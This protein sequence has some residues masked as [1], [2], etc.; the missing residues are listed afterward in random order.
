[1]LLDEIV[2]GVPLAL[3]ALLVLGNALG[4]AGLTGDAELSSGDLHDGAELTESGPLAA[5][6]VGHVPLSIVLML[7]TLSFGASG[8]VALGVLSRVTS[9]GIGLALSLVFALLA[10]RFLTRASVRWLR[11]ILPSVET[12]ASEKR[13]LVGHSGTV[14]IVVGPRDVVMRVLDPG[15]AELRLRGISREKAPRA[16][17]QVLLTRYHPLRD[18]FDVEPF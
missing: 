13:E 9:E 3:G 2:F 7:L 5:L 17:A 11:R 10:A 6:G 8:F 14:L 1:M 4:L 15:G 12:Y 16:G 18:V